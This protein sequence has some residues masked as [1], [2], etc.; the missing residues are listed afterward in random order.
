MKIKNAQIYDPGVTKTQNHPR[1]FVLKAP[2]EESICVTE[3]FLLPFL[4][5]NI[6]YSQTSPPLVPLETNLRM[7]SLNQGL[8][9]TFFV[10]VCCR[11]FCVVCSQVCLWRHWSVTCMIEYIN[12][13]N[14]G[15]YLFQ[16]GAIQMSLLC[17]GLFIIVK[18][19]CMLFDSNESDCG[20]SLAVVLLCFLYSV[21]QWFESAIKV[22]CSSSTLGQVLKFRFQ[23]TKKIS[24]KLCEW[25]MAWRGERDR[26]W[27]MKCSSFLSWGQKNTSKWG[28]LDHEMFY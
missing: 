25:G 6:S 1:L 12:V 14:M 24:W 8:R 28:F 22:W 9:L 26:I 10:S 13:H 5:P 17:L 19:F 4:F 23:E 3:G 15:L 7:V 27:S 2:A 16:Q 11:A 20:G 18:S 21:K